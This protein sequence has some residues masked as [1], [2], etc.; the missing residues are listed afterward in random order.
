MTDYYD[1]VSTIQKWES[2]C[3]QES[4]DSF[5]F[6]VDFKQN[7]IQIGADNFLQK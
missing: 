5:T 1:D 7:L 6:E 4:I 3:Q 2:I